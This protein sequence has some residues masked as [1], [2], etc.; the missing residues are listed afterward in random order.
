MPPAVAGAFMAHVLVAVIEDLQLDRVERDLQAPADR[1]D[2]QF[3]R[4]LARGRRQRAGTDG[5]GHGSTL[6]NGR[7]STR[8]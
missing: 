3:A 7:T 8:A 1:L 6:R 4:H 2:P 5:A